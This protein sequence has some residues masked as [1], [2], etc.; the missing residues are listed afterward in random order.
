MKVFWSAKPSQAERT[1]E[2]DV[3][4]TNWD[5]YPSGTALT[6]P[7]FSCAGL[8]GL[9]IQFYP[10]GSSRAGQNNSSVRIYSVNHPGVVVKWMIAFKKSD[11]V[12]MAAPTQ[13]DLNRKGHH[14]ISLSSKGLL[15]KISVE[16]MSVVH[17]YQPEEVQQVP[18]F[19]GGVLR[20]V[21]DSTIARE[22]FFVVG[23]E[24]RFKSRT[25]NSHLGK[26]GE[27]MAV[28]R[29]H[30]QLKHHD[31]ALLLWGHGALLPCFTS[32]EVD[33]MKVRRSNHPTG[34]PDRAMYVVYLPQLPVQK[35]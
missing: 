7:E 19:R 12:Q 24:H 8:D 26:I 27:V 22:S 33:A 2:W 23:C 16:V 10:K 31:G 9:R 28:E 4:K 14:I 25:H 6:S 11:S 3:S 17:K 21:K 15:K 5:L 35:N 1:H 13:R 32:A 30:I 18:C 20:V 34:I 29:L